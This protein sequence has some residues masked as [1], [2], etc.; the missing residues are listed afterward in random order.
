M[1][2]YYIESGEWQKILI[3]SD[4]I[5]A[6]IGALTDYIDE[7]ECGTHKLSDVVVV[8]QGG[9]IR[10]LY[11]EDEVDREVRIDKHIIL[12][13]LIISRALSLVKKS[14]EDIVVFLPTK[15][16]LKLIGLCEAKCVDDLSDEDCK[17][18]KVME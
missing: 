7:N 11:K 16:L 12:K 14:E 4:F 18:L 5:N 6:A 17:D 9:F 1:P 15:K 8:N 13:D 10:D 3:A 2:K